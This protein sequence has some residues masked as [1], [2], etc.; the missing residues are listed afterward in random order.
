[1]TRLRVLFIDD[2]EDD[3]LL[4]A[5]ELRR[6][7][8]E[9]VS[10]QVCSAPSVRAAF[11]DP[12]DVVISDWSMPDSFTGLDAFEIMRELGVDAPFIIVSGTIGEDIA[13][14]ALKA[15]V[16]DFMTKG[17]FARLV[18]TIERELREVAVRKRERD[19]EVQL[20]AKRN[21]LER[22]ERLLREVLGA[23]PDGVVVVD[24]NREV[25][26]SNAAAVQLLGRSGAELASWIGQ[27]APITLALRGVSVD[28]EELV[29]RLDNGKRRWL[30]VSTRPL[31]DESGIHGA[32]AVFLDMTHEKESQE[33]LMIS[34]RM[35]S[36]G[37][38]AAGV[39]HE[40]NNPLAA[41]LANIQLAGSLIEELATDATTRELAEMIDDAQKAGDRVRL[42]V[43]DLRI[44]ARHE[45]TSN[46]AV[47]LRALLESTTRMAWNEIRHRARLVQD[48]AETPPVRGSESRLGQ[49]FLNLIVNAAQAIGEGNAADHKIRIAT[50]VADSGDVVIEISDTGVGMSAETQRQLFTPFFTTKPQGEGTGLGLT[51]S[52]RIVTNLGGSIRV[53]STEGQGTSFFVTLPRA[54]PTMPRTRTPSRIPRPRNGRIL[55]I[56]DETMITTTLGRL[57]GD[58][59]VKTS[60]DAREALG[61]LRAGE[62]FDAILCDLMM[63][64]MTGMEFHGQLDAIAPEQ[65]AQVIFM[66]GE[67]F[68]VAARAFLDQVPN[69]RIGKPFDMHELRRLLSRCLR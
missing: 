51:I 42:I 26:T 53:D 43:R 67:A 66:T 19:A 55:V 69:D 9:L 58:H 65:A 23:V 8:Y 25:R 6:G 33:Q 35:A 22:S 45:D 46:A 34:D 64:E 68:T 56:D 21:E 61:W 50:S 14:D 44:F 47:D 32:L 1:M 2:S 17:K 48:F 7:G 37:M 5:R 54:M 29:I 20:A 36:I 41:V 60:N 15:G 10:R 52:H 27:Q 13:V 31:R 30:K 4:V 11:A 38:L 57:L 39:A 49:V 63:P 24:A 3:A 59:E 40:L 62:R 28:R 18:P 12:W 16:H